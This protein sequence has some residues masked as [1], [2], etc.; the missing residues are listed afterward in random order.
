M[1]ANPHKTSKVGSTV[2]IC[3]TPEDVKIAATESNYYTNHELVTKLN[4]LCM[5]V[6]FF[7]IRRETT[8]VAG[9]ITELNSYRNMAYARGWSVDSNNIWTIK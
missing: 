4:T 3:I 5:M 7:G 2:T 1:G 9:L 8:V 6:D